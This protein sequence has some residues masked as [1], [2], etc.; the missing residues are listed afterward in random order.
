MTFFQCF[1]A[2]VYVCSVR[3]CECVTVLHV[4]ML[5]DNGHCQPTDALIH[6]LTDCLIS[7]SGAICGNAMGSMR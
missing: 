5:S 2:S 3:D 4:D 6:R 1:S 7:L